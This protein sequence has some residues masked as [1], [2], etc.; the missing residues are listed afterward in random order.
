MKDVSE[1]HV[2]VHVDVTLRNRAH[3]M[4]RACIMAPLALLLLGE[5]AE[6]ELGQPLGAS[7]HAFVLR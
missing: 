3:A 1:L 5:H 7:A 2:H 6:C 4:V